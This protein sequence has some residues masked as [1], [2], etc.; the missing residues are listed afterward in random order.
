MFKSL[1][2]DL[3]ADLDNLNA[4]QISGKQMVFALY[5]VFFFFLII[6]IPCFFFDKLRRESWNSRMMLRLVPFVEITE[7]TIKEMSEYTKM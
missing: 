4:N 3:M 1:T 7:G 2:T 5:I 6:M